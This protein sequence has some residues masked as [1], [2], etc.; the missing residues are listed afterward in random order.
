MQRDLESVPCVR[1]PCGKVHSF[2]H[3]DRKKCDYLAVSLEINK[4]TYSLL[5]QME[6]KNRN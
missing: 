5:D 6:A 4:T 2:G 3:D 1:N